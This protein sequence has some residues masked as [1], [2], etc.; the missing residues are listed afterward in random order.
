MDAGRPAVVPPLAPVSGLALT[1]RELQHWGESFGKAARSPLVVAIRG[2]LG[3]GKTTL[4]RA[5]CRGYGVE[6]PATSPTYAIVHQ[7]EGR[8]PV[9]HL[10]LYRLESEGDLVNVG[11]DEIVSAPA[12]VLVEWPERAGTALPADHIRL[13]L[14]HVPGDDAR[15]ILLAG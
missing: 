9:Y 13:A 1:E 4:V 7:Y 15:R 6:E 12:L 3:A 5:I 14:E 11:W 10:D 2:E 8:S